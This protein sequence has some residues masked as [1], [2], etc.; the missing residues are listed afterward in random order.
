MTAHRSA[1]VGR[2][3]RL[4][5]GG[6]GALARPLSETAP[7]AEERV[8]PRTLVLW[9][10]EEPLLRV[11]RADRIGAFFPD[12]TVTEPPG[13]GHFSPLEAPDAVADA[14]RRLI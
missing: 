14:V 12:A 2:Q 8:A 7:P 1:P 3:H 10:S 13:I 9:G 6:G 11:E 5:P 4:V